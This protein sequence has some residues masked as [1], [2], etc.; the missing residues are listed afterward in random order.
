MTY[1]NYLVMRTQYCGESSSF[2]MKSFSGSGVCCDTN[3]NT[4][5]FNDHD[6]GGG[7]EN[8]TY[9]NSPEEL[10]IGFSRWYLRKGEKEDYHMCN[11]I[12]S[13]TATYRFFRVVDDLDD[14]GV[15]MR[16]ANSDLSS[17]EITEEAF[18]KEMLTSWAFKQVG[19]MYLGRPTTR[20][21][22][23]GV[24]VTVVYNAEFDTWDWISSYLDKKEYEEMT[25]QEITL[26]THITPDT[27]YKYISNLYHSEYRFAG[28]DSYNKRKALEEKFN[29]R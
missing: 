10:L 18:I 22:Q 15:E 16:K 29:E 28:D 20:P 27:V 1:Y 8:D 12:Y 26:P 9:W 11:R 3:T 13:A 2:L 24:V 19:D 14:N 4:T 5:S 21:D 7:H 17:Y 25:T 6:F 23:N